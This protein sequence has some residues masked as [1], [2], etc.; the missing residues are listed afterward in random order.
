MVFFRWGYINYWNDDFYLQWNH[1]LFFTVTEIF[2]TVLVINLAN[3]REVFSLRKALG[4]VGIAA[5]HVL[6]GG[7]DQFVNNVVRGEGH[8]HQVIL[9]NLF[10]ILCY[11]SKLLFLVD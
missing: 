2:S 9:S 6:A 4:I 11:I 10:I 5:L 7:W 8:A 3:R 1:Q